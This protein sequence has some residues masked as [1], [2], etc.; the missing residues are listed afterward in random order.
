[1]TMINFSCTNIPVFDVLRCSWDLTKTELNVLK[2]LTDEAT[3]NEVKDRHDISMSLA[4]RTMKSLHDK[5]LVTRRQVNRRSGG[6]TY[7]YERRPR[8]ELV[9]DVK[10]IIDDWS[11]RAKQAV[12]DD[13]FTEET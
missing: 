3:T 7:V 2:G 11:E 1:M 10:R 9:N 5:D 12:Q 13:A 4:Q 6:Y 8:T